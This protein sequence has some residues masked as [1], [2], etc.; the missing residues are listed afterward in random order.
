MI[1]PSDAAEPMENAEATDPIDPI[2]SAD[3]TEPIDS[4]DP[5]EPIDSSE[6]SD[7]SDHFE[8]DRRSAALGECWLPTDD[9]FGKAV[10][11]REPRCRLIAE[12]IAAAN[13]VG[14]VWVYFEKV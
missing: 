1:D 12:A 3:P 7:Q 11:A 6:S 10:N 9:T 8:P 2:E 4:T 14:A 13:G 5:R